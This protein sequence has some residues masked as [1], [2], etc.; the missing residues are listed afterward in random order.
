M[1]RSRFFLLMVVFVA[2]SALLT[3]AQTASIQGTVFDRAGAVVTGAEIIV[4]NVGTGQ[5]RTATSSGTGF[6][7]L[8]TLP[9]GAYQIEIK[10]A[11]LVEIMMFLRDTNPWLF[12][13]LADV[14]TPAIDAVLDESQDGAATGKADPALQRFGHFV[15]FFEAILAYHRAAGGR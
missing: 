1:R 10:K 12:T 8:T 3:F 11:R 7:S 13:Y 2:S 6:Y 4:T 14:L 5:V 9:V 15:D